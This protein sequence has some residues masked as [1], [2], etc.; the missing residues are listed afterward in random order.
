MYICVCKGITDTHIKQAVD[1]G[2]TSMSKLRKQLD[3]GT[4]CGSCVS[5]AKALVKSYQ[6]SEQTREKLAG[7]AC[8]A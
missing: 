7:L 2:A 3:L 8:V 5:D 6:L 4:C 1:E